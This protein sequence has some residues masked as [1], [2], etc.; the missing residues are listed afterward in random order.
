MKILKLLFQRIKITNSILILTPQGKR[1]IAI[2]YVCKTNESDTIKLN[3]SE[4][5][6]YN[7]VPVY[8]K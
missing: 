6:V 4:N 1:D 7:S 8:I 3:A 5:F 2:S